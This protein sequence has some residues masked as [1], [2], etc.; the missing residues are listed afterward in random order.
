MLI[1]FISP[2]V[3]FTTTPYYCFIVSWKCNYQMVS[4]YLASPDIWLIATYPSHTKT[5]LSVEIHFLMPNFHRRLGYRSGGHPKFNPNDVLYS[6]GNL[7]RDFPKCGQRTIFHD[8]RTSRIIGGSLV[9]YGAYP[10]VVSMGCISNT[11]LMIVWMGL[12]I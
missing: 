7:D 4:L 11:G 10:W 2:S 3:L 1:T 8:S 12:E 5:R 9:P 6:R